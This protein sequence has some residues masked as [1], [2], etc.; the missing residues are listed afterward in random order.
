MF[1]VVDRDKAFILYSRHKGFERDGAAWPSP[2][3][4]EHLGKGMLWDLCRYGDSLHSGWRNILDIVIRLHKLNLLPPSV[5]IMES[6]DP[7]AA[8]QRLP[9]PPVSRRTPSAGS[10]ISRA[11][12]RFVAHANCPLLAGALQTDENPAIGLDCEALFCMIEC[13]GTS[14]V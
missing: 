12:S 2:T 7:E 14:S 11:F 1:V 10:I 8:L 13:C 6:E 4:A 5:L 3:L 9:R